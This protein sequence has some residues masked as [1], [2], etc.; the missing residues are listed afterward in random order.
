[1]AVPIICIAVRVLRASILSELK[2]DYVTYARARGFSNTQIIFGEVL[3]NALPAAITLFAQYCA[4]LFGT[5][6]LVESVFSIDGLGMYLMESCESMDVYG[7][8]GSVLVCAILFVLFNTM[9]DII[10]SVL[11]P[12]YRREIV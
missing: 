7:I 6:A 11:C 10:S 2:S 5:S 8:S 3:K 12:A 9:A 1:M 4:A